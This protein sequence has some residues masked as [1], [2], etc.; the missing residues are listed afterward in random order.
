MNIKYNQT[1]Y[2]K[3]VKKTGKRNPGD[4]LINNQKFY[5]SRKWR[6]ARTE[7]IKMNP[8]CEHCLSENRHT[9]GDVVDHIVP[10]EVDPTL[11]LDGDNL[12]TL[13]HAHHNAKTEEDK[14]QYPEVYK[15]Y[16]RYYK[17]K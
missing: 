2:A 12:Q 9:P 3:T 14:K 4:R 13:C 16:D 15:D 10:V 5:S 6:K 11:S 8:L 17:N 1:P 7:W